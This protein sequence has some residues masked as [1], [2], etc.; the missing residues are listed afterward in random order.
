MLVLIA[1]GCGLGVHRAPT[2]VIRNRNNYSTGFNSRG[3]CS[4]RGT[5]LACNPFGICRAA[6]N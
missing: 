2:D 6:R 3:E 1:S 5:H 4:G